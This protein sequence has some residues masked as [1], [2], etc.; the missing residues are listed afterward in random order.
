MSTTPAQDTHTTAPTRVA[1]EET[2]TSARAFP[3]V[4]LIVALFVLMTGL[5]ATAGFL[6]R[7][8]AGVPLAIQA[9][10][11]AAGG[12]F[13]GALAFALWRA[14]FDRKTSQAVA[15]TG[16]ADLHDAIESLGDGFAY[17]DADD[18]L[19]Y[20]NG[21]YAEMCGSLEDTLQPGISY[22]AFVAIAA[23][24]E[25]V[26][27]SIGRSADWAQKTLEQHRAATGAREREW[28]RG[29][30]YRIT[31]RR[32][33]QGGILTHVAD[34]TALRQREIALKDSEERYTLAM[35]GA[36]EGLWD[37]RIDRNELHVSPRIS[38]LLNIH[39]AD[40]QA[41]SKEWLARVHPDDRE[42]HQEAFKAH[43]RGDT[44]VYHCE[45]RL[46]GD[47]GVM[48]WIADR[49]LGLR[50]STGR[51][52]RMAG[53]V[54]EIT[55]RKNAEVELREAKDQAE[56]ANRTKSEFL[57][58]VSHELRTPLNA[59]IGFS[60]MMKQELFGPLGAS[61][62]GE[63]AQDI[64]ASGH[65]LLAII[66][67]ILDVS[68]AEAGKL[69]LLEG[70]VDLRRCIDVCL[71]LV[72]ERAEEAGV[73]QR[74]ALDEDLP[75]LFADERKLKQMLINL[76]SNAVKFT[77]D[78]GLV[79]LGGGLE[80]D[81]GLALWVKDTGVG[82]AAD[83]IEKALS[84][85]EQVDSSLNRRHTGTGLGLP[86]VSAL[87]S[88]HGGTLDVASEPGVGTLATLHFPADR[89]IR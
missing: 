4:A 33:R 3:D 9:I 60:D 57:A 2:G 21:K 77:P 61:D 7:D 63:Y 55:E 29:N 72:A 25:F 76:L 37:W 71:R 41:T 70:D 85:F 62:Y 13:A 73:E 82:M 30:W 88:L 38:A 89:V 26:R 22:E 8:A 69:E 53:S 51:V 54:G 34:V 46:R 64:N 20:F 10:V 6:L 80:A 67:D 65:H 84:P 56:F 24:R 17:W 49:G 39:F 15:A 79:T 83:T 52:Y 11:P 45:Y 32:A 58:N 86:I 18:R 12:A 81:G 19:V 47:D 43:L 75:T 78:G 40:D 42:V 66:N 50:D 68:K 1:D 87:V 16:M 14:S 36:N 5:A 59:I 27:D 31:E 35:L 23:E 28:G 44:P 74:V 48:R